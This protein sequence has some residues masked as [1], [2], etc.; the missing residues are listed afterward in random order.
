[1]RTCKIMSRRVCETYMQPQGIVRISKNS[2]GTLL[3]SNFN[4]RGVNSREI[5]R[6]GGHNSEP[7][8]S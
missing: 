1:M 8:R 4:S 2:L 7:V 3:R 5:Y 6:F